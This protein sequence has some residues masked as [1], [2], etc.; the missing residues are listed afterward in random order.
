MNKDGLFYIEVLSEQDTL[1]N[2][3]ESGVAHTPYETEAIFYS[4]VRAGD[5]EGVKAAFSDFISSGVVVGR[6]SSNPLRQAQYWAVCCITMGTRYAIQGGLDEATAY[7]LSDVYIR[8]VD[9][10]ENP[11]QVTDFVTAKA[12]ELTAMVRDCRFRGDYP[13]A[14]VRCINYISKHLHGRLT[15]PQL[16]AECNLSPDYLTVLFKKY[17]GMSVSAYVTEQKLEAAKAM[18]NGK[19]EY[20]AIG[21]Y[22]GFSSESH[23]IS[24]FKKKYGVTPKQYAATLKY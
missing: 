12:L 4:K 19:Y 3:R 16:A 22:L 23:F 1:F 14:V 15:V 2:S 10:M 24:S 11:E 20:S 6:M 5:V 7:N 13:A 17:T 18:L 9:K 21:Y 8:S